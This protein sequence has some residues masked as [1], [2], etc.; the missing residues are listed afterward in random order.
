[1]A[2]SRILLLLI[3]LISSHLPEVQGRSI[4]FW[5]QPDNFL[6]NMAEKHFN[7]D[8]ANCTG[9]DTLHSPVQLPCEGI[10]PA[11]WANKDLIQKSEQ[12]MGVFLV[13]QDEIQ[14]ARNHT[15]L[16]T[17]ACQTSLLE[18]LEHHIKNCV[19]ILKTLHNQLPHMQNDTF[20][21]AAQRCA[22]Q[23][24]L[25]V[26]VEKYTKLVSRYLMRLATDLR[27]SSMCNT[28]HT[29]SETKVI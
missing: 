12:V 7:S 20:H 17:P 29:T 27:E 21:P 1:M 13:F 5:C 4:D 16:Q 14:R 11:E 18:K 26:V 10:Q 8:L 3:G 24:S 23:T 2:C 28:Q 19:M 9:S 6:S 25:K 15:T 22:K